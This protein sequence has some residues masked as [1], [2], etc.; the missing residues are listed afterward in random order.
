MGSGLCEFQAQIGIVRW[1]LSTVCCVCM[2]GVLSATSSYSWTHCLWLALCSYEFL[3]LDRYLGVIPEKN[4]WYVRWFAIMLGTVTNREHAGPWT[5]VNHCMYPE[6]Q[7]AYMPCHSVD[8]ERVCSESNK[9]LLASS[10]EPLLNPCRSLQAVIFCFTQRY[11][12]LLSVC[13]TL[14]DLSVSLFARR[15]YLSTPALSLGGAVLT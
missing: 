12:V 2:R 3:V 4:R 13:R 5:Y 1:K 8:P 10:S 14:I 9:C 6:C 11:V 7:P 15:V